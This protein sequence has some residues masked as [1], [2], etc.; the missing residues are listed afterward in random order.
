MGCRSGNVTNAAASMTGQQTVEE[1]A[2]LMVRAHP[3][4]ITL[5]ETGDRG[6]LQDIDVPADLAGRA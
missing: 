1:G 5:Y 3:G 4:A 6:V 2:R